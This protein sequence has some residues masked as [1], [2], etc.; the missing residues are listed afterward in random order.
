MRIAIDARAYFQRTGIARYTRELV[1][2]VIDASPRDEFLL[3]ISDRHRPDEVPVLGDRVE[4]RVSRAGWLEGRVERKQ[5]EREVRD[6]RADLFHSIFPPLSIGHV[7]SIV[8]VFDLTPLSHPQFHQ[9]A[10]V[11]AFR[12]AIRPA[13]AGAARVVAISEATAG[14]ARRRFPQSAARTC[15]AGVGLPAPFVD[16][17]PAFG[18]RSGV[19]FVGTIEPRKNVP[20]VVETVR[21]L[22]ARGYRGPVTIV[23]KPGWGDFDITQ[24]IADIKGVHYHGYVDDRVLRAL[25]R[26]AALFLYPSA[27]EGF[28]L[29]VLEAM[30]QGA[31]PLIS[32]DAA[33]REVV[34]DPALVVD[35]TDPDAVADSILRWSA[36]RAAR[37]VKTERLARRA[38]GYTW[39]RAARQITRL[40]RQIA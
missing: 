21:R 27:V 24:A 14:E 9:P 3:L 31:L 35:V 23:G 15:V 26:R 33:L 17:F 13:L 36:D 16:A 39:Q 34:R 22:R 25:Y 11:R 12:S 19:L 10:V 8:T 18:R 30:S 32:P 40:Y 1:H 2:A 38:R 6:W 37:E 28:G 5:I 20:L 29:P 7:R 4:V